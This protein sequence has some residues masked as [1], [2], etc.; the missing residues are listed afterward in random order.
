MDRGEW[1]L[2]RTST[3]EPAACLRLLWSDPEVWPGAQ[4]PAGYLHGLVIDRRFA[5]TGLGAGLPR[6]AEIRALVAGVQ[7]LRLDCVETNRALRAYYAGRGWRE[8][9]RRDFAGPWF[10]AVLMEK[11]L[12][13]GPSRT[14]GDRSSTRGRL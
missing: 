3:G 7:V 14:G 9:G 10:S 11:Q 1:H 8:V 4:E 6:W 12:P 5:G 2:A 13:D